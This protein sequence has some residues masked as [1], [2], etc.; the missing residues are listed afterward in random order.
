MANSALW[1]IQASHAVL[2]LKSCIPCLLT[3]EKDTAL[4]SLEC[5]CVFPLNIIGTDVSINKIAL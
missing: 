1:I 5:A 4:F 3:D 2:E